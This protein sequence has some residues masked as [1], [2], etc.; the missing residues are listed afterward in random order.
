M[1]FLP[2]Y[3]L[4]HFHRPASCLQFTVRCVIEY[5]LSLYISRKKLD[6][7]LCSY[8]YEVRYVLVTWTSFLLPS[9]EYF[10]FERRIFL[11]KIYF[12]RTLIKLCLAVEPIGLILVNRYLYIA[13]SS[14]VP[15]RFFLNRFSCTNIHICFEVLVLLYACNFLSVRPY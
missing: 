12:L 1:C 6:L 2:Y 5:S 10:I 8:T 7:L 3:S 14:E 9:Y 13:C 15:Y 4:G 11:V